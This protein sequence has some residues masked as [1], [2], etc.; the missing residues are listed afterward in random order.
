MD[1]L[2]VNMD[3]HTPQAGDYLAPDSWP[4]GEKLLAPDQWD[5]DKAFCQFRIHCEALAMVGAGPLALNVKVTG[6]PH[7]IYEGWGAKYRSRV[8]VEF[9]HDD[10]PSTFTGGWIYHD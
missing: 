10:D 8:K 6:K 1:I 5:T 7:Y 3:K 2:Q 4:T 9:P